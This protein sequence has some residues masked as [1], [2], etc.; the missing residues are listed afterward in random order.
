MMKSVELGRSSRISAEAANSITAKAKE[1]ASTQTAPEPSKASKP[2][3]GDSVEQSESP[4]KSWAAEAQVK[5]EKVAPKATEVVEETAEAAQVKGTDATDAEANEE[6]GVGRS[7]L[8]LSL[9]N[10][11][12]GDAFDSGDIPPLATEETEAGN[13]QSRIAEGAKNEHAPEYDSSLHKSYYMA[14]D[15][16]DGKVVYETFKNEGTFVLVDADGNE[17]KFVAANLKQSDLETIAETGQ[18]PEASETDETDAP[19]EEGES[20]EADPASPNEKSS[21]LSKFDKLR[22]ENLEK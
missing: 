3:K 12:L 21:T 5:I 16:E 19:A 1:V 14:E 17:T 2:A 7:K 22:R 20:S 18:L 4:V 10:F 8:L 9:A 6:K 13:S 15:G 11:I